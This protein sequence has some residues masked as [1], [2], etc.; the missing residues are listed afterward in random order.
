MAAEPWAFSNMSLATEFRR[1]VSGERK[2]AFAWLSRILLRVASL[3][4]GWVVA[5]RNRRYDRGQ[6]AIHQVGIPVVCVGNL[7]V[8]G[9]GKTPMVAYLCRWFRERGVRVAVVSRGYRGDHQNLN[10]EGRELNDRLPDVPQ[11][12]N[13]DRVAAAQVAEQELDMQAIVLDDGFQHRRLARDLDIVLIDALQ[14]FGFDYLLPGGLLRESPSGLRRAHVVAL[15]RAA[16]LAPHQ[17]E[18]LR[19]SVSAFA[20]DARWIELDHAPVGLLT[21]N[22]SAETVEMI[23]E[24]R[25]FAFCGLGNPLGFQHTL[26]TCRADVIEFQEFPDHH[27]Y[28]RQD[29]ESLSARLKLLQP[30]YAICT[31]KDLVKIELDEIDGVPLRALLV[32]QRILEGEAV[33]EQ[34]LQGLLKEIAEHKT[35]ASADASIEHF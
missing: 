24:K 23:Q 26:K 29:I 10:D 20:P 12:Q 21:A 35:Q 7:T 33:L 3:P 28:S 13:P 31:H 25:V 34:T 11:I 2:D 17:R 5:A 9:T 16:S 30:D 15:T 8:G 19:A 4:Y 32:E 6:L 22:G 1:I 18:Q 27:E 14:P